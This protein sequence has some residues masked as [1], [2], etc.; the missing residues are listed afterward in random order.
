MYRGLSPWLRYPDLSPP[1]LLDQSKNVTVKCKDLS[2]IVQGSKF[3]LRWGPKASR[4]INDFKKSVITDWKYNSTFFINLD[5]IDKISQVILAQLVGNYSQIKYMS[6]IFSIHL[7]II[8]KWWGLYRHIPFMNS[9]KKFFYI[10]PTYVVRVQY[11]IYT[12]IAWFTINANTL[13]GCGT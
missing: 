2:Q 9:K 3:S 4:F 6:K 7:F 12:L 13:E 8:I 10:C 1:K 11:S 5:F